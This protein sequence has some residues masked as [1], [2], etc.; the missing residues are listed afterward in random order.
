MVI[1]LKDKQGNLSG[2]G[3]NWSLFGF[4]DG[5]K[6][7]SDAD[8]F[9]RIAA[10]MNQGTKAGKALAKEYQNLT[11]SGQNFARELVHAK[12]PIEET[13]QG[14]LSAAQS[15]NKFSFATKAAELGMKALSIAG[16]MVFMAGISQIL[17]IPSRII[18][19]QENARKSAIDSA[20]NFQEDL[21][22]FDEYKK[23]IEEL[24]TA[25]DSGNLS[26]AESYD[27][28][29]QLIEIQ[30]SIIEKYGK[31]AGAIDLVN[32]RLREQ[33]RV[34]DEITVKEAQRNLD[35]N[36]S[37]YEKAAHKMEGKKLYN[38]GLDVSGNAREALD[39]L[40][41]EFE[42]RGIFID[43]NSDSGS[44]NIRLYAN[45]EDALQTITDFSSKLSDLDIDHYAKD[46]IGNYIED[47]TNKAQKILDKWSEI[48]NERNFER[49]I[50]DNDYSKIYQEAE[51]ALEH[52]IE[53]VKKGDQEQISSALEVVA[54]IKEKALA[55]DDIGYQNFFEKYFFQVDTE[56][57]KHQFK[58]DIE[59]NTDGV[60]Q[61]LNDLDGLDD[62][63]IL[64]I[65][66][67]EG[68]PDQE[69]AF[70]L[71]S[72]KAEEYGT[73]IENLIDWLVEFGM[74]Q[75]RVADNTN[76][77]PLSF[78]LS[79]I[80]DNLKSFND[81]IMQVYASM[82]LLDKAAD[83]FSQSGIVT[84]QTFKSLSDNNLLQ[85]L[86]FTS[87]GLTILTNELL[88]NEQAVKQKA[89]AD[90][91]AALYADLS[92][93]A[94]RNLTDAQ[95]LAEQA[96]IN[97]GDAALTA[98][99][100][101][102]QSATGIL[103]ATE[104]INLYN[105]VSGMAGFDFK[106]QEQQVAQVIEKYNSAS[107]AI[108]NMRSTTDS[109]SNSF[110][111]MASS[112]KNAANEIKQAMQSAQS[113]INSL[114]S[115]AMN[116]IKQE[117]ENK[118]KQLQQDLND[119]KDEY[120]AEK[121]RIDDL[122]KSKKDALDAE[123]KALEKLSKEKQKQYNKDKQAIEDEIAA[124]EKIRD[125]KLEA[126]QAEK[127][128][129]YWEKELGEFNKSIA[130]L[131]SDIAIASKDD[132]QEGIARRKELEEQL[133]QKKEEL[134]DK[135]FDR[136]I[137]QQEDAINKEFDRFKELKDN[138]L[139][140]LDRNF[141][142]EKEQHD[143]K[144][145]QLDE[146]ADRLQ[147]QH[148][149]ALDR[150]ESRYEANRAS[151]E[152]QL[153]DLNEYTSIEGNIRKE[154]IALMESGTQEFYNRLMQWNLDYGDGLTSTVE[155]AWSK[156]YAA[157]DTYNNGQ[158]NVLD[159]LNDLAYKMNE[160]ESATKRAAS[161]ISNLG[162]SWSGTRSKLQS[163]LNSLLKYND[164][165]N[166]KYDNRIAEL[167]EQL[168]RLDR[169]DTGGVDTTGGLKIMHGSS[170]SPEVVFNAFDAKKLYDFVHRTPDLAGSIMRQ[171]DDRFNKIRK[172]S[173]ISSFSSQTGDISIKQGDVIVQ[174]GMDKS[175]LQNVKQ[176]FTDNAKL[177][178][179]LV[180]DEI[181]KQQ[182]RRGYG[183]I[184]Y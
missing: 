152:K 148:Q 67:I 96:S 22:S 147:K 177:L 2:K 94:T 58:I 118:K 53:A 125:I 128:A 30:S 164:K 74:V 63:G 73:S 75:S 19:A 91:A 56:L 168:R 132:S 105:K 79:D 69:A 98:G 12:K 149:A 133:A 34:L 138:E 71:L 33:K 107:R 37:T 87:D 84:A 135:Q 154:A 48:Y 52:Y 92:N 102:A 38:I 113:A 70:D 151:L 16:N 142:R 181:M 130:E 90:L 134:A 5:N 15:A 81:E 178:K 35:A 126:L 143:Q 23:K 50:T 117:Y 59:A 110:H 11:V 161:A 109:A 171:M 28:R 112:A 60:K 116:M 160:F 144:M 42:S 99:Q 88:T 121:D 46:T 78:D 100:K 43:E 7:N 174:G 29:A 9:K 24:Q 122:Y 40:V 51:D 72:Q 183:N 115:M 158:R 123:K 153:N 47:S 175:A 62:L 137:E 129:Y 166:G 25:I 21:K 159:T 68:T 18:Q 49:I 8:V 167:Q 184:A 141:E 170:K 61:A 1:K 146:E 169:Y 17:S 44:F 27:A 114:L 111:R 13:R 3:F 157:L 41:A 64:N 131:E 57:N 80:S 95:Y 136:S 127:D 165:A 120:D 124:Q 104:A 20:K 173:N 93:I 182:H 97:S 39:S 82:D 89:Q 4:L 32:G 45:A 163:E 77:A 139:D 140:I 108:E 145:Q 83:E 101:F 65:G 156:C 26:Q 85:Y 6:V 119:L 36:K 172:S 103:T 150:I 55:T 66:Q 86:Q 54:T 179:D 76:Q 106:S 180:C 162:S 31:E 155:L 176:V 14:F 10:D